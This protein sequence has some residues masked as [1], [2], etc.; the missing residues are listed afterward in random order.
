MIKRSRIPLDYELYPGSIVGM[1]ECE[2]IIECMQDYG[3]AKVGFLF[4]RGY[5]TEENVTSL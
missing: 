2:C 3:Y 1:T 4:D 5:Y